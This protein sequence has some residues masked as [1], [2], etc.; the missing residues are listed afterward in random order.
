M[1]ESV[2]LADITDGFPSMFRDAGKYFCECN[3]NPPALFWLCWL[4]R[5]LESSAVNSHLQGFFF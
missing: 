4:S 5:A 1:Y 2:D 3:A